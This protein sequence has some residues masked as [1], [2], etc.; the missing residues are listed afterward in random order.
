MIGNDDCC[1]KPSSEDYY[2][3]LSSIGSFVPHLLSNF[4]LKTKFV[5]LT[6]FVQSY[7][8]FWSSLSTAFCFNDPM[9]CR[10]LRLRKKFTE[11]NFEC[12]G[13]TLLL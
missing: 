10:S 6:Y 4:D 1:S 12:R 2:S 13:F 8:N 7:L 9:H 3:H 11:F 5:G